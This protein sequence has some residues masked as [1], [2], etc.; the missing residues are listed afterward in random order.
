MD[1]IH[2]STK[3]KMQ[4]IADEFQGQVDE[5]ERQLAIKKVN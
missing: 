4:E 2:F 1:A 3:R 5:L